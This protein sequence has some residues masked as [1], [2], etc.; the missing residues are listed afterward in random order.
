MLFFILVLFSFSSIMHGAHM[1]APPPFSGGIVTLQFKNGAETEFSLKDAQLFGT[2]K[3]MVE[4]LGANQYIPIPLYQIE[5]AQNFKLLIALITVF[6][7]NK[8]KPPAIVKSLLKQQLDPIKTPVLLQQLLMNANYL[9]SSKD[10]IDIFAQ[11]FA[12]Y[13]TDMELPKPIDMPFELQ[14]KVV[15]HLLSLTNFIPILHIQSYDFIYQRYNN[16]QG[17]TYTNILYD[18]WY[19]FHGERQT[20]IFI[21]FSKIIA[22][23]VSNEVKKWYPYEEVL[24][25]IRKRK[26][27]RSDEKLKELGVI[28]NKIEYN[29]PG[30]WTNPA[31]YGPQHTIPQIKIYI[32]DYLPNDSAIHLGP[33]TRIYNY[34]S[35]QT[36]KDFFIWRNTFKQLTEPVYGD[37][38][39]KIVWIEK[40]KLTEPKFTILENIYQTIVGRSPLDLFTDIIIDVNGKT[41]TIF[42]TISPKSPVMAGKKIKR[43]TGERQFTIIDDDYV[44]HYQ[45]IF[46]YFE[47]EKQLPVVEWMP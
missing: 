15:S 12:E 9:E 2:I 18:M 46:A 27:E 44:S 34:N 25:G 26:T 29:E 35:N 1:P 36:K 20:S 31:M 24:E 21:G 45:K 7:K 3:N 42:V 28:M 33:L 43:S 6:E 41:T 30:H 39:H 32:K 4:D 40:L 22:P 38:I 17:A 8:N 14:E 19:T 11:I 10:F 16:K 37:N 5:N 23:Y 47:R 13:L